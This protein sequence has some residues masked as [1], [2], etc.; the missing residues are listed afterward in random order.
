MLY[1][2][3]KGNDEMSFIPNCR[4]DEYYNQK[5]LTGEDKEFIRGYDWCT[6]MVVDNFFDNFFDVDNDFIRHYLSQKVPDYLKKEYDMIFSFHPYA[7]NG[8]EHRETR[9]I[10]TYEDILRYKMLEWIERRRDEMITSM[11]D[12]MCDEEFKKVKSEVDILKATLSG[13]EPLSEGGFSM[14]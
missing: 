4:E 12:D 10:E 14:P 6:E 1:P 2:K 3:M 11:I 7:E 13:I 9:K 8:E 5:Y